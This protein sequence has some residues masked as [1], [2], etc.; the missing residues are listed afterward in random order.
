MDTIIPT[1][2]KVVRYEHWPLAKATLYNNK[3][4]IM[5][6]GIWQSCMVEEK[7]GPISGL[8]IIIQLL[9]ISI[10]AIYFLVV[11][12]LFNKLTQLSKKLL[13]F[14]DKTIKQMTFKPQIFLE[15]IEMLV[16][17]FRHSFNC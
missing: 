2:C 9:S 1:L 4:I 8:D 3:P 7:L 11:V 14:P 5:G 15:H 12:Y 17:K 6:G 16:S 13:N 10:V